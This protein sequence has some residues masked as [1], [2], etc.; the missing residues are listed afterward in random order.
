MDKA[1][2]V[3]RMEIGTR[4]SGKTINKMGKA[5]CTLQQVEI[6]TK[7]SGSGAKWMEKVFTLVLM[8]RNASKYGT[9]TPRFGKD[10]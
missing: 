10:Q 8:A 3:L 4:V 9:T 6:A 5:P 7:G 1:L 2:A